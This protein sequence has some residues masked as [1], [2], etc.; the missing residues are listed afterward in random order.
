MELRTFEASYGDQS[1]LLL[2][3]G[4]FLVSGLF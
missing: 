3:T 2:F 1:A 4:F